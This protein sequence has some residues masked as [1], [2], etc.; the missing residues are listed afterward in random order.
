MDLLKKLHNLAI[1]NAFN[2]KETTDFINLVTSGTSI[3]DAIDMVEEGISQNKSVKE[4]VTIDDFNVG[5]YEEWLSLTHQL[6][7][8]INEMEMNMDCDEED[9]FA[10][11]CFVSC[12]IIIK[13]INDK[14]YIDSFFQYLLDKHEEPDPDDKRVL[15]KMYTRSFEKLDPAFKLWTKNPATGHHLASAILK[16]INGDDSEELGI[17]GADECMTV[18]EFFAEQ[19]KYL[20]EKQHSLRKRISENKPVKENITIDDFYKEMLREQ[21]KWTNHLHSLI[22]ELGYDAKDVEGGC[23]IVSC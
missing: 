23:G 22:K 15:I 18:F 16:I 3:D 14:E 2:E 9:L 11:S 10:N 4:D 5:M 19:F 21:L 17:Y 1:Q 7:V 20:L 8:L 13:A 6:K 12:W